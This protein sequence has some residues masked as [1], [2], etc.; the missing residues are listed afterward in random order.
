[1]CFVILCIKCYRGIYSESFGSHVSRIKSKFL[2]M[3][4]KDA[5][6]VHPGRGSN[7]LADVQKRREKFSSAKKVR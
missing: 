2:H 5:P 1:M 3:A 7:G 6:N 4:D